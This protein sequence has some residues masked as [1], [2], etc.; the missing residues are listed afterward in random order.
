LDEAVSLPV[1]EVLWRMIELLEKLV[2]M[3]TLVS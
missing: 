1:L 2:S 3:M